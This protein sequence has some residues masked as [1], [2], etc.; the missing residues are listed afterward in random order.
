MVRSSPLYAAFL[1]PERYHSERHANV[2]DS[3]P[4]HN[5]LKELLPPKANG[6]A[7][8]NGGTKRID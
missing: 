3:R 1:A 4:A 8:M 7:T 2:D 5:V 6:T